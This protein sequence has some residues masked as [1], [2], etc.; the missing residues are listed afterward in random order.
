MPVFYLYHSVGTTRWYIQ[1]MNITIG[2]DFNNARSD[3]KIVT[4]FIKWKWMNRIST[5]FSLL[6]WFF[7]S[8]GS[9]GLNAVVKWFF[10]LAWLSCHVEGLMDTIDKPY[11]RIERNYDTQWMPVELLWLLPRATILTLEIP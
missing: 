10:I 6:H 8:D 4:E 7:Y 1:Q 9:N 11:N 3:T 5:I 2:Y